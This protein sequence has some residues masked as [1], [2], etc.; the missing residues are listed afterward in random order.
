MTMSKGFH[1]TY[2]R[3]SKAKPQ[4][5]RISKIGSIPSCL[6][7]AL[8]ELISEDW[9]IAIRMKR[10]FNNC[11]N[12][13]DADDCNDEELCG[14]VITAKQKKISCIQPIIDEEFRINLLEKYGHS[15]ANAFWDD[16]SVTESKK[17]QIYT[18]ATLSTTKATG[19][20]VSKVPQRYAPSAM[21]RGNLKYYNRIGGQWR[22]VAS[23]GVLY[24]RVNLCSLRKKRNLRSLWDHSGEAK[25]QEKENI[26]LVHT[27]S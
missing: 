14:Q 22:I 23:N 13:D 12:S 21:L 6:N 16:D 7:D 10:N 26:T 18:S 20:C 3:P 1:P 5:T 8:S 9:K 25:S 19:G 2:K 17:T 24:P 4:T 15:V 11:C 27:A